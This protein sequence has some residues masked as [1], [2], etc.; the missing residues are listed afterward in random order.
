MTVKIFE[1]EAL[2]EELNVTYDYLRSIVLRFQHGEISEFRGYSFFGRPHKAWY[3]VQVGSDI[4]VVKSKKS[5]LKTS[6]SPGLAEG[7]A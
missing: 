4:E 2:A 6:K 5:A 1:L 7:T 3:G